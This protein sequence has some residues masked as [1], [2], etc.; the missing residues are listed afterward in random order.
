M[1]NNKGA[2][3]GKRKSK[4]SKAAKPRRKSAV[5]VPLEDEA[6]AARRVTLARTK[7]AE[8]MKDPELR[9]QLVRAIR[10]MIRDGRDES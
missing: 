10:T 3:K 6:R 2:D 8:A 1:S 7:L 4:S 5:V 9:D